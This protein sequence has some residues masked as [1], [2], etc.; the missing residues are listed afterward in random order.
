MEHETFVL[1]CGCERFISARRPN[2]GPRPPP[3]SGAG[4]AAGLT[5]QVPGALPPGIIYDCPGGGPG[6]LPPVSPRSKVP[7]PLVDLGT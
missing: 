6:P 1:R 5:P 3:F 2:E 7:P 4:S